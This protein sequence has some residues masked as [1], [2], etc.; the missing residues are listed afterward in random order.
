MLRPSRSSLFSARS[1]LLLALL[2]STT[3]GCGRIA[4]VSD[5]Y[6]NF[7]AYYNT[8]YNA[9]RSFRE[10]IE[11]IE[12]STES[13]NREQYLPV[14]PAPGQTSNDQRFQAAIDKS[15]DVLRDHPNSK[16]VDDALV[17]IG[18][19][20]YYQRN[21]VSAE[22]KFREAIDLGTVLEDEARLWLARTLIASGSYD[23]ARDHL[24]ASLLLED[25]SDR[26][27][28]S[29]RLAMGELHVKRGAFEDAADELLAGLENIR[30]SRIEARG[31]FVLGQVYETLGRY[32]DAVEAFDQVSRA[33]PRYELAYAA[34]LSAIRVHGTYTDGDSAL[35]ELRRMERDDKNYVNRFEMA[36][37]RG[38]IY[39]SEG[40]AG[41]AQALYHDILYNSD[42]QISD[43]RGRIH[44]ALGELHRDAFRDFKM[45]A[46]HFDTARTAIQT[47]SASVGGGI[48]GEVQPAPEAITDASEQA[49]MFGSF[50]S[51]SG[52][53]VEMDSLL[54]LGDLSEDE[55]S[56]RILEIRTSIAEELAEEARRVERLQ[57]QQGFQNTVD[58]G[59][60]R[61]SATQAQ[62]DPS[63]SSG[64]LF[65]TD[66]IRVQ[67]GRM[68]FIVR[69]GDRP[70]AP[71][72]RR[73][74][75]IEGVAATADSAGD[76]PGERLRD[77]D[78][79]VG[80]NP[81]PP[82]DY[83]D[84]PRD[85][86]SRAALRARRAAAR[87][88]L[89]NVLFLSM[90][91]P[92]S[93]AS[94]YRAVIDEDSEYPVAQRAYYALA[95]V[96][97]S[98]GDSASANRLYEQVLRDFPDSDF[99]G[100]VREQLGIRVDVPFDSLALAEENYERAFYRW[101][102]G[103]YSDALNHMVELA[104][105]Y[106]GLEVAPRA[107]LAAGRIFL[108]WA[109]RDTLD[110]Y[111]PL[112]LTVPD[113][114][115]DNAGLLDVAV[116][117][118]PDTSQTEIEGASDA[119]DAAELS[120]SVLE[121]NPPDSLQTDRIGTADVGS[122]EERDRPVVRDG[123]TEIPDTVPV[124]GA[125]SV[126]AQ[127]VDTAQ[128]NAAIAQDLRDERDNR[129]ADSSAVEGADVGVDTL[130][131]VELS[132][133]GDEL[134]ASTELVTENQQEP[135]L[136]DDTLSA[137]DPTS[138]MPGDRSET[139]S[140][141]AVAAIDSSSAADA[142]RVAHADTVATPPL[143]LA[144]A[145]EDDEVY[146]KT[147]YAG[148][149]Q[150]YPSS[151]YAEEADR[152]LQALDERQVELRAVA[153]SLAAAAADSMAALAAESMIDSS[154]VSMD[155]LL[156]DSLLIDTDSTIT[157]VITNVGDSPV[158]GTESVTGERVAEPDTL[159]LIDAP[160]ER[161]TL[162]EIDA[163]V[164]RDTLVEIDA[165]VE[166]ETLVERN[167]PVEGDTLVEDATLSAGDQGMAV[168]TL[169]EAYSRAL[170]DS[171]LTWPSL[172]VDAFPP[173]GDEAIR[174]EGGISEDLGG[175]TLVL[176]VDT[177]KETIIALVDK[178]ARQGFRTDVIVGTEGDEM[179]YRAL[180]GQFATRRDAEMMMEKY[181]SQ[182]VDE[183]QL[184]SLDDLK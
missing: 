154:G 5:R 33:H 147:L 153:D 121:E 130:Y 67:E 174:G 106:R 123:L 34:Q 44:Y 3:A 76:Q 14:F 15:A 171:G 148:V 71:N 137:S 79:S 4:F 90:D 161:D 168:D 19:C 46:A 85:S 51:V 13:I 177:R 84:V 144:T 167:A 26:W 166:G 173:A 92:D 104:A 136:A 141:P 45:A 80:E 105:M 87:Y 43:V 69:W 129:A 180:L 77:L 175:Y 128:A 146:L 27:E 117:T 118:S 160:V 149:R 86:L 82:L 73:L 38:L 31:W 65:H 134:N 145:A 110:V 12:Q 96:H 60:D 88:E 22:Q 7:T 140:L 176:G 164:E 75:A 21:F 101:R 25:L 95:E 20:Y 23:E 39:Q 40:Y 125:S 100:R 116:A 159:V 163:P 37:V 143:F 48:Q 64:F 36:Y 184:T 150:N 57:A 93:A 1:L 139:D 182:I 172:S 152:L 83:S 109:D 62:N 135:T 6:D 18:K 55:F 127:V 132:H 32:T 122:Q 133:A 158:E 155:S 112:P 102:G 169:A 126:T 91:L 151:A 119:G 52:R 120:G 10:G 42:G 47:P 157:G 156:V 9:E 41:D 162:V 56:A 8:F 68:N 183:V 98:L 78:P 113:S 16:W 108:E 142:D 94:W 35:R 24:Q 59:I 66:P 72:W 115:L 178:Y 138:R 17:L 81:L 61:S 114:V 111:G 70:H 50:A 89:A 49:E 63:G 54:H 99:A 11:V 28:P 131:G 179:T 29:L 165:P 30:D 170:S 74:A 58:D 2:L 53:L 103:A 97:R 181:R 124:D 107:L